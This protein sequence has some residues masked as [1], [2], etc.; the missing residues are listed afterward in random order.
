MLV[1]AMIQLQSVAE[2]EFES[3]QQGATFIIRT[4]SGGQGNVQ[5]TQSIHLV[6]VD[7]RED[8]LL[9][10]AHA[11]VATTIE[12]LGIQ[13]AEV[14]HARQGD[15]QQ[16]IQEL[17]HT[18]TAQSYFNADRPALTNLEAC[19]RLTGISHNDFLTG[20][21]FQVGNSVLDDF[22]ITHQAVALCLLPSYTFHRHPA[23]YLC[24]LLQ[25]QRL[26]V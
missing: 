15:G 16:T 6:V 26:G 9:F 12:G 11:V 23:V 8:D 17:V 24:N 21:L 1:L 20:N 2:R 10:H 7:F 3:T 5:T 19:N 13:A 25:Q 22:L 18:L 14:T 4:G